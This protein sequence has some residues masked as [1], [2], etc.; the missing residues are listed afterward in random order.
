MINNLI[1]IHIYYQ[2]RIVS[3]KKDH[4]NGSLNFNQERFY[5]FLLRYY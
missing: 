4:L 2:R 1:I 3:I 5:V